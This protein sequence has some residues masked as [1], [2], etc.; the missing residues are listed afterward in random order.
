M[1]V[2]LGVV[3]RLAASAIA[4]LLL[5]GVISAG[6]SSSGGGV[7]KPEPTKNPMAERAAKTG[8]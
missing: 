5:L 6:C 1:G 7:I 4:T 3:R 8:Q 2:F